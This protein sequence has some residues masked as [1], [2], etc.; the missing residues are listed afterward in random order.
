MATERFEG[1]PSADIFQRANFVARPGFPA[2]YEH[3]GSLTE[4]AREFGLSQRDVESLRKVVGMV[5]CLGNSYAKGGLSTGF[6]YGN[7]GQIVTTAHSLYDKETGR[8]STPCFFRLNQ[9]PEAR[10]ELDLTEGGYQFLHKSGVR[11]AGTDLAFVR[12]KGRIPVVRTIPTTYTPDFQSLPVKPLDKLFVVSALDSRLKKRIG[13]GEL[14]AQ[15]C[16][17]MDVFGE[18]DVSATYVFGNCTV[19]KG[20]SGAVG[21]VR[22]E[23]GKFDARVVITRTGDRKY[24][25]T[26]FD[27]KTSSSFGLGIDGAVASQMREFEAWPRSKGALRY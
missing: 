2:D 11:G 5:Q 7:G 1:H 15:Q 19:E 13:A 18:D 9:F 20:S 14:V 12:L 22:N 23:H 27:I 16:E 24:D 10:V 3:R 26:P 17:A 25:Y 4:K 6:A 8:L 21:F